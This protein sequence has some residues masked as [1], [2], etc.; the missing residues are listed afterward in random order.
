MHALHVK[1]G[2]FDYHGVAAHGVLAIV[3]LPHMVCSL[4]WNC[5][6]WCARYRGVAAHGVLVLVELPHMVCSLSCSGRA[7]HV[8]AGC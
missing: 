1:S 3:E 2:R 6:T 7:Q 4:S 8:K 5:R